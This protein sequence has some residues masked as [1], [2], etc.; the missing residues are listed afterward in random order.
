MKKNTFYIIGIIFLIISF[1]ID[2]KVSLFFS[3]IRNETFNSIS[4]FISYINTISL[5]VITTLI[6]YLIKKRKEII[7]M[8]A[9]F[10]ISGVAS[11]VIKLLTER[12]R[13]F[14]E[15]GFDA[16]HGINF[17]FAIWNSSFP[18][19]HAAALF[20]VYPFLNKKIRYY[21]IAFALIVI[22]NRVY[23]GFHYLSDVVAGVLLGHAIVWLVIYLNKRFKILR[24]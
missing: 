23:T 24:I 4:F 11:L 7:L 12:T 6:L 17:D 22:V 21:W 14:V 10:F 1:F 20:V 3:S 19:W 15:F 9:A 13:P 8:W 18:S 16:I 2:G 5:F